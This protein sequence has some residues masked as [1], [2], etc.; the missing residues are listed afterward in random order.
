MA[1]GLQCIGVDLP[2][3]ESVAGI[4]DAIL[5]QAEQIRGG[6]IEVHRWQDAGSGARI[7]VSLQGTRPIGLLASLAS[8]PGVVFGTVRRF[9]GVA[10]EATVLDAGG[11][12]PTRLVC[13]LEEGRLARRLHDVGPVG[14]VALAT[15][16]TL[17]DEVDAF[18]R[19]RGLPLGEGLLVSLALMHP[20]VCWDASG[21]LEG[22]VLLAEE[23]VNATGGGSFQVARVRAAGLEVDVCLSAHEHRAPVRPGQVI[24]GQVYLVGSVPAGVNGRWSRRG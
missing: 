24:A 2:G 4:V 20:P 15:R 1:S 6:R 8:A 21:V 5:P 14:V 10:S 16:V 11:G 9:H 13:D 3:G 18:E 17:H 7:V 19:A 12:E 22:V 23:R